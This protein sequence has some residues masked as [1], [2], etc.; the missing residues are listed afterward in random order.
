MGTLLSFVRGQE[1]IPNQIRAGRGFFML[2]VQVLVLYSGQE[3][4]H[5]PE[6]RQE[7]VP[8]ATESNSG[9]LQIWGDNNNISLNTAYWHL[10]LW[11]QVGSNQLY[12]TTRHL[13]D[14][15]IVYR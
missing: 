11:D 6:I 3:L 12:P 13:S 2:C 8:L 15:K 10:F 9:R 14:D 7:L 5:I 1:H 4:V